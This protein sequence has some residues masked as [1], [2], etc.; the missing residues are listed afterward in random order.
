V[1]PLPT[2]AP[3]VPFASP[4]VAGEGDWHP[5]G[6]TVGGTPAVYEA[7]LR[8][9]AVHTSLVAGVAWIDTRLVSATLYSGS[10]IPGGGPF[11]HQAPIEP[12]AARRL[13]ALF[14]AGFLL[15]DSLGGYYT[16]G[17]AEVPLR[18]GAA[19]FVIYK[20]GRV[21]IG[22]WGSDVTMTP[23]VVSVRQNLVPLVEHGQPAPGLNATD[24]TQW[25]F[26]LGNQYFVSRSGV[27]ITAD[28]ALVYVAGD[29]DIT[30][31]AAL[32]VRAGAVRAMEL[33]INP[34][35]VDFATYA[36]AAGQLASASNGSNLLSSMVSDGPARCFWSWWERDFFTLSARY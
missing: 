22:A 29:T 23:D 6:R 11:T 5:A 33:D 32:L 2:P 16:D 19:S 12:D 18:D 1:T 20:G 13:V 30:D 27:G 7:F 28:G 3:L 14:N 4:A 24:T 17:R 8:P 15:S 34:A 25:G 9:D 35:W 21:D 26:T 36:P 31:L 10:L